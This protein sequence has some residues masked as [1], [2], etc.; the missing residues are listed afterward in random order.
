[1]NEKETRLMRLFIFLVI[2]GIIEGWI[3]L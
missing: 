2:I 1:M 3:I